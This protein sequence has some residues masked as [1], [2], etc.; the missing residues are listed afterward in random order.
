[1]EAYFYNP[2]MG[3]TINKLCKFF[4]CGPDAE[5]HLTNICIILALP[6]LYRGASQPAG[7]RKPVLCKLTCDEGG[8]G[9][10]SSAHHPAY[11]HRVELN[12]N[13]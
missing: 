2:P 1:M 10:P 7:C 11:A 3:Y 9:L 5:K 4:P 8:G 12:A 13:L 6:T